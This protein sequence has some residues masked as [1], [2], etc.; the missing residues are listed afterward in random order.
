MDALLAEVKALRA[1]LARLHAKVSAPASGTLSIDQVRERLGL[2]RTSIFRL[3]RAGILRRGGRGRGTRVTLESV[4]AYEAPERGGAL[5]T[6]AAPAV[7]V[8]T[9]FSIEEQR[10]RRAARKALER[11]GGVNLGPKSAVDERNSSSKR[12]GRL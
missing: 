11:S 5:P 7:S 10:A 1:E 6:R 4:L 2:E 3:L 12:R 9:P 8:P